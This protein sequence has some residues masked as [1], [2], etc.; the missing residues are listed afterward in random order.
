MVNGPLGSGRGDWQHAALDL[1]GSIGWRSRYTEI[2]F[3]DPPYLVLQA[4]PVFPG[5]QDRLAER[6]VVW[7]PLALAESI[8]R[9][10]AH[11]LLTSDCGYAPDAGIEQA[12]LVS[13]PDSGTVV[14]E[15]DIKGLRP[16]VDDSCL[17]SQG[18]LRLVFVREDYEGC[19]G[20][21][22]R[23]L[24]DWATRPNIPSDLSGVFGLDHL[25]E[26]Y[27]DLQ[28]IW[29][30]ELEPNVQ[31]GALERLLGLD[32]D[33]PRRRTPIWPR[34]TVVDIGFFD[35]GYGH[36]LMAVDGEPL[37]ATW[38]GSYFTRWEA[39]A[40]F[41]GWLASVHRA[42]SLPAGYLRSTGDAGNRFVLLQESDRS[43]CHEAGRRL[44]KVLQECCEEGETAPGVTVRYLERDLSAAVVA[45]GP[46]GKG[47]EP[48]S[49]L[50]GG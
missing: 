36:E 33:A 41:R 30:D 42:W 31:G 5:A 11:Y 34:G 18:F 25:R 40:A 9:P 1:P 10:G 35:V 17:P 12:V 21:M 23:E 38:P 32:L 43:R 22:L 29:V 7:D 4:A 19:I 3:A 15:L 28:S 49:A 37:K 39:L 45:V 16:A 13:H 27:P 8:I 24:R 47:T 14:W 44:A 20:D 26:E 50:R 48:A 46:G 6:G 2:V